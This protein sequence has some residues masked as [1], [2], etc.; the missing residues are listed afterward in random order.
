MYS[1]GRGITARV[2]EKYLIIDAEYPSR[3]MNPEQP[4]CVLCEQ[5]G[6]FD[7]H[8]KMN[9]CPITQRPHSARVS[10]RCGTLTAWA[11]VILSSV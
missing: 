9:K 3:E 10:S 5:V 8:T 11:Y 2:S 7:L 6:V 1:V 4:T